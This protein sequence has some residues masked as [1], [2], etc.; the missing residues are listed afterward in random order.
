MKELSLHHL[1]L[2]FIFPGVKPDEMPEN[3]SPFNLPNWSV[4]QVCCYCSQILVSPLAGFVSSHS[5]SLS[6]LSCRPPFSRACNKSSASCFHDDVDCDTDEFFLLPLSFCP[7]CKHK[8]CFTKQLQKLS[9]GYVCMYMYQLSAS[10]IFQRKWRSSYIPP[11]LF[12][13]S[14]VLPRHSLH[15]RRQLNPFKPHTGNFLRVQTT[16]LNPHPISH[17]SRKNPPQEHLQNQKSSSLSL[18]HTRLPL[19][20]ILLLLLPPLPLPINNPR[21][22]PALRESISERPNSI[23]FFFSSSSSSLFSLDVQLIFSR[24]RRVLFQHSARVRGLCTT[25]A[26][27]WY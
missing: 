14:F 27:S 15:C 19:I 11:S 4:R 10:Y 9:H 2:S 7:F 3:H 5:L 18:T 6:F 25:D 26:A 17:G 22:R 21:D 16:I 13:A 23:H 12:S 24:R 20:L 1:L 8:N